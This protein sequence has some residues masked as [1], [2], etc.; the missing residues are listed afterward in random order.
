MAGFDLRYLGIPGIQNMLTA[1][2]NLVPDNMLT[3][4]PAQSPGIDPTATAAIP[5]PQAPIQVPQGDLNYFPPMPDE[6]RAPVTSRPFEM[7]SQSAGVDPTA[8]GSNSRQQGPSGFDKFLGFLQGL[9]TGTNAIQGI[10]NAISGAKY[11]TQQNQ[12]VQY[13]TG[14]GF[15]QPDAQMIASNPNALGVVLT[16]IYKGQDPRAAL[17][18]QKLGYETEKA[19][20]E[21][22]A[23]IKPNLINAGDGNI[24]N[25]DSQTW[26]TAPNGGMKKPS[27]VQEYEYAKGQ[28]FP[29]T[30]QDWEA[31]KKGGMSLQVDPETGA[32][33]FQQGGNI[34]PMTE[35]QSKDTTYATRAAGALPI[36]DQYGN[37]L[38][39]IT[40]QVGGNL[41]VA[42]NYIK[43]PEYQQ[44]EQAG[45]EFLQAILRKDTGAAIT[46]EETQEYGRVYLPQP[47]DSAEVL[48]QKKAARARALNALEAGMTPQALLAKERALK[49]G[50][51]SG[52]PDT[53][54][55]PLGIR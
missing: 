23:P 33:S 31:S 42:G 17:E 15:S 13:L 14:K 1:Q 3:S 41:P 39:S 43:S 38:T 44:A 50:V 5:Q 46:K 51:S 35:G 19:R 52:A 30:F 4:I 7:P 12:T 53:N 48:N 8:T 26:M 25:A 54:S 49:K 11:G 37:A 27:A 45:T 28:G 47:G 22:T 18:L 32:I 21:A 2:P 55:D 36:L 9:G 16:N 6:N 34:K 10:S 20:R 40:E 29:G 24:Y